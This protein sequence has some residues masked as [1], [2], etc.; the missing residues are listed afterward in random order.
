MERKSKT[1]GSEGSPVG[2][3]ALCVNLRKKILFS[4]RSLF[5]GQRFFSLF[6]TFN[7]MTNMLCYYGIKL[8]IV[9]FTRLVI[10]TTATKF[11]V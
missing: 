4:I 9:R 5:P 7:K 10:N 6:C 3:L 2:L 11:G 1:T 8:A